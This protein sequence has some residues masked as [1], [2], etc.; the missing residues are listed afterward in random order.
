[1]HN[2]SCKVDTSSST[3]SALPWIAW[4]ARL[5]LFYPKNKSQF[6]FKGA[7]TFDTMMRFLILLVGLVH[8]LGE[9]NK[10]CKV[11]ICNSK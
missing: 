6:R 5:P 8:A 1:M 2:N 4:I 11:Q 10:K 3:L 7:F 9:V